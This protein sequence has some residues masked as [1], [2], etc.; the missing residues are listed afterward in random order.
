[1]IDLNNVTLVSVSSIKVKETVEALV[2]SMRGIKYEEVLFIS[3]E[4]PANMPKGI[5]FRQCGIIDTVDEYSRFI[6]YDLC[7]YIKSDYILLVQYDGYVLRPKK[8]DDNFFNYDYIGAPWPARMNFE[9][10]NIPV[11]VG[12]GGFSFRSKK[13]LNAMN[14][15]NLPFTNGK[16]DTFNEDVVLCV[17]YKTELEDYGIKFSPL[18]VALTFSHE[19]E[20]LEVSHNPF[21]FHK[22]KK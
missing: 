21:G 6:L 17:Y 19:L 16:Y 4:E 9:N 15:L 20:C 18:D 12:N 2:R 11:R 14:E 5:Q 13:L 3:H 22:F 1:M 10:D 7:K 8:W